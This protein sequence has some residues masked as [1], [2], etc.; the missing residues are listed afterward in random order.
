MDVSQ[1]SLEGGHHGLDV[2]VCGAAAS[3]PGAEATAEEKRAS[4]PEGSPGVGGAGP[5]PEGL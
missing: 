1:L 2:R 5:G 3:T 4:P